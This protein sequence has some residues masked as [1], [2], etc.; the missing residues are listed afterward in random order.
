MNLIFR[1]K[2]QIYAE[3]ED[4]QVSLISS[5]EVIKGEQVD[6]NCMDEKSNRTWLTWE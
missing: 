6:Y 5:Y 3:D 4:G 1:L 2:E